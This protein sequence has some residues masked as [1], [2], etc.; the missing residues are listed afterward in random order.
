MRCEMDAEPGPEQPLYFSEVV[1]RLER[2]LPSL[3][4]ARRYGREMEVRGLVAARPP[5]AAKRWFTERRAL[6]WEICK[7]SE[8]L[9]LLT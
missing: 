3:R 1:T 5:G 9:T 7:I 6:R 4:T 8:R 2:G